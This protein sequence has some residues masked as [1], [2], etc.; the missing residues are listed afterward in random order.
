M[1]AGATLAG[2]AGLDVGPVA[3]DTKDSGLRYYPSV[4]FL[5]VRSDG[6]GGLSTDIV[7]LPDTTQKMSIRPYAY[8]ASNDATLTFTNGTLGE[9]KMVADETAVPA[10][11][12]DAASKAA[13]A[14]AAADMVGGTS[15]APSGPAKAPVPYLYKIIVTPT[16]LDLKG[17]PAEDGDGKK[18]IIHVNIVPPAPKS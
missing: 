4:P 15:G 3:D 12:L 2:C 9:A 16:G 14:A 10:A 5:F 18:A 1:L 11:I 17:G 13:V 8:M 6:K 7:Y